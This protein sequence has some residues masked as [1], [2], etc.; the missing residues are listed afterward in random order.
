MSLVTP[1]ADE[2]AFTPADGVPSPSG[3]P[4][5]RR[6]WPW[7]RILLIA[8]GLFVLLIAWLAWTA[9]LGRALEPLE[10]PALVLLD[11][12]GRPFAR[13][14]DLKEEPVDIVELPPHVVDAVLSTEDR[15]FY[16]HIGVDF[17]GLG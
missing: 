16:E 13:R 12:E 3:E 10:Q 1:A 6:R 2:P 14:G 15:R 17:R 4:P 5:A 9:P 11:D 8:A 7:K